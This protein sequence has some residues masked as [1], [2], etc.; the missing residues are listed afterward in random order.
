M[1]SHWS[2]S[3]QSPMR[4]WLS[5]PSGMRPQ[6][7]QPILAAGAYDC[8]VPSL[9]KRNGRRLQGSELFLEDNAEHISELYRL[10]HPSLQLAGRLQAGDVLN[11][12]NQGSPGLPA[13]AVP[14]RTT[15]GQRRVMG[16]D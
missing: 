4:P 8:T 1:T 7:G 13:S 16:V 5:D 10:A 2:A 11:R 14:P 12:C 9:K 15:A 6:Y 3:T